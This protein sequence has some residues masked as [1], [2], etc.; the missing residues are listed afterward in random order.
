LDSPHSNTFVLQKLALCHFSCP[1][2]M[3][4]FSC[5]RQNVRPIL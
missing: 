4:D 5:S 3:W 1:S 2:G